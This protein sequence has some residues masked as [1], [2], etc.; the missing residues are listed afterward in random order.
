MT[1][2]TTRTIVDDPT[3]G[4]WSWYRRNDGRYQVNSVE[5]PTYGFAM[6]EGALRHSCSE[7]MKAVW[8][9]VILTDRAECEW[10]LFCDQPSVALVRHP[11]LDLVPTC[12]HCVE[13]FA[14]QPISH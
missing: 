6:T 14:L 3:G 7:S 11:V 2:K 4:Q 8:R 9:S 5:V 12:A 1:T 10:M 13:T